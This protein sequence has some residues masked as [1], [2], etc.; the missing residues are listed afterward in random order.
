MYSHN[1]EKIK[2]IIQ[3]SR[4]PSNSDLERILE[5]AELKKGLELEEV[6]ALLQIKNDAQRDRLF[7]SA[8]KVKNEIYFFT[9]VPEYKS[10]YS[11]AFSFEPL[12]PEP[13][14]P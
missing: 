4:I 9:S 10:F 2:K 13:L 6:A 1:E 12:N 11:H 5:K 8:G 7:R 14:N 3:D